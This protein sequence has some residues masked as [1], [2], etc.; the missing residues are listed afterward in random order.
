MPRTFLDRRR[1]CGSLTGRRRRTECLPTSSLVVRV[2]W[3]ASLLSLGLLWT[4]AAVIA[5]AIASSSTSIPRSTRGPLT[6]KH[7]IRP[8]LARRCILPHHLRENL[9]PVIFRGG[10]VGVEI[11]DLAIPEP[12][13]ESFFDEHVSFF[14]LGEGALATSTAFAGY[15][16]LKQRRAIVNQLGCLG[17][18]DR[19]SRLACRLVIR[20]QLGPVE[21]EE[22]ATPVLG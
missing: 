19:C 17:E 18:I 12:D 4:A 14:F 8:G 9:H 16:F 1:W 22:A 5:I 2:A 11:D 21:L 6:S 10:A 3:L 20:G 7:Q 13:P 15:F